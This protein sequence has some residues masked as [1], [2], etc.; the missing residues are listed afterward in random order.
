MSDMHGLVGR[1]VGVEVSN[2][3]MTAVCLDADGQVVGTKRAEVDFAQ[4][5]SKQAI[6][7]IAG[8]EAD[9][10]EFSSVGVAVPGLIAAGGRSVAF[11]LHIPE[12]SGLDLADQIET[13]TGKRTLLEN[14]ANAAAF[15]EFHLGAGRGANNIFY[16]TLGKGVGGAMVFNGKIWRGT[17]GYAGEFGYIP[18]NSEGVR[19]EEVASSANVIRRT[20]SRF[21]QDSTS[22]LVDLDE[23]QLTIADIVAAAEAGDDFAKLMLERTGNYVGTGVAC[24]I[25]LV[26]IERVI[27]GGEI[28]GGKHI[29]LEYIIKRA[30]ELSFGPS[31]A[32]TLITAGEL[33]TA[34]AAT[35]AAL[36]AGQAG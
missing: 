31:F 19:L 3:A 35:G 20:R 18:I 13:A 21:Y 7:F 2:T 8:L 36:L 14:D 23:A 24:V 29:I 27:V 32:S 25:N 17:A 26:N 33:G 15:G 11:S 22:S 30:K 4:P 6:A 12:H 1:S 16:A 10:G 5:S 28:M 34:A 9:L